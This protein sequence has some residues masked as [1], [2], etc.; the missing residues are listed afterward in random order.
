[1]ANNMP[2]L[3]DLL[4]EQQTV[5]QTS[6]EIVVFNAKVRGSDRRVSAKVIPFYPRSDSGKKIRRELAMIR[7]FQCCKQVVPWL[8]SHRSAI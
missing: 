5:S 6:K 8:G 7:H 4:E 3:S 2:E 1:M